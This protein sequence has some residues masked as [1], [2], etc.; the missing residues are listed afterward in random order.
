[1]TAVDVFLCE[2]KYFES[3]GEETAGG[4]R[5]FDVLEKLR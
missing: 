5:K 3:T 1:M 4:C 2:V